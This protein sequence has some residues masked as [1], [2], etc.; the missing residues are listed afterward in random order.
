MNRT[1]KEGDEEGL[2][3]FGKHQSNLAGKWTRNS[4]RGQRGLQDIRTMMAG[5]G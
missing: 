5:T 1:E 3:D 4:R 2:W